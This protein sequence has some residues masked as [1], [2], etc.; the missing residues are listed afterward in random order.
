HVAQ[1]QRSALRDMD[2]PDGLPERLHDMLTEVKKIN[3]VSDRYVPALRDWVANGAASPFALGPDEVVARSQPRPIETSQAA[4]NFE[5]GQEL[6]RAGER[7]AAVKFFRRAHELAPQNWTYKRQ[8]WTLASTHEGEASDL[9]QGPTD[10]YDGNWLDDVRAIGA[11]HYYEP[12][13]F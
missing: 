6:W 11:D 3:D 4:A 12:L 13:D 8:A 10:S 7:Q 5:L 1:V 9:M 2:I